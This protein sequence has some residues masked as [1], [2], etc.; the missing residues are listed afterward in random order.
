MTVKAKK[1]AKSSKHMKKGKKIQPV[2]NLTLAVRK[3][4]GSQPVEF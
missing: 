3:A 1:A 4:G 2:K